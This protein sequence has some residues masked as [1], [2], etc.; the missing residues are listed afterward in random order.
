MD[1]PQLTHSAEMAA[2]G[3]GVALLHFTILLMGMKNNYI[4]GYTT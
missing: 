1:P 4:S 2:E 3:V